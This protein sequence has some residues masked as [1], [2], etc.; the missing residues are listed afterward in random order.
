MMNV[1]YDDDDYIHMDKI[2]S[3][4]IFIIYIQLIYI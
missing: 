3:E 1:I 4:N 2:I